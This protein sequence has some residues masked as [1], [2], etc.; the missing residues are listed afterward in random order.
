MFTQTALLEYRHGSQERGRGIFEEVLR[1]YPKRLDIWNTYLDQVGA[2]PHRVLCNN[3][4][5]LPPLAALLAEGLKWLSVSF[6]QMT[7]ALVA[8]QH[9]VLYSNAGRSSQAGTHA[10]CMLL[11]PSWALS[12]D[13]ERRPRLCAAHIRP[14][15]LHGSPTQEDEGRPPPWASLL[16]SGPARLH[17]ASS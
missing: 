17:E 16:Q 11:L 13:S 5:M 14:S 1:T 9:T 15:N 6:P 7:G 4:V 2:G 12:G 8:A 10:I 3:A